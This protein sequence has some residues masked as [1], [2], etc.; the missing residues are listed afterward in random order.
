VES[1]SAKASKPLR[2]KL[3]VHRV[4]QTGW[5]RLVVACKRQRLPGVPE[6]VTKMQPLAITAVPGEQVDASRLA[7]LVMELWLAPSVAITE[8]GWRPGGVGPAVVT[9]IMAVADGVV[10]VNRTGLGVKAAVASAGRP[11]A[12]R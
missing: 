2:L 5:A 8:K 3:V 1:R 9:T 12:F 11:T 10:P 4:V 6:K 7:V